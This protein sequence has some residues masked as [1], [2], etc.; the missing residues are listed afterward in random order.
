MLR[1]KISTPKSGNAE[2]GFHPIRVITR[3]MAQTLS[4]VDEGSSHE[5]ESNKKKQGH[6]QK[7][8]I[9]EREEKKNKKI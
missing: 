4:W 1:N 9:R 3:N 7:K 2:G 6:L 5:M 8:V